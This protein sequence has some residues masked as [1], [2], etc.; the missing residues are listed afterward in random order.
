MYL[1][2]FLLCMGCH[3][4]FCKNHVVISTKLI[5]SALV[6]CLLQKKKNKKTVVLAYW[7]WQRN[8]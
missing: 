1:F 7:F 8:K 2:Y 3:F 4:L 5:M 6:R